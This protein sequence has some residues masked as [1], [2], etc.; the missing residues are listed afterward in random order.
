MATV[1]G[2][3]L[4]GHSDHPASHDGQRLAFLVERLNRKRRVRRGLEGERTVLVDRDRTQ[5][6]L[7]V[8]TRFEPDGSMPAAADVSVVIGEDAKFPDRTARDSLKP[9]SAVDV[10]TEDRRRGAFNGPVGD[11]RRG[12]ANGQRDRLEDVVFL[13][14]VDGDHVVEH[15][16]QAERPLP[17]G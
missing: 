13:V 1:A 9:A 6:P 8:P 5:N 10:S 7:D 3:P 17:A 15:V 16:D 14:G 2:E 11:K 12:L 4:A